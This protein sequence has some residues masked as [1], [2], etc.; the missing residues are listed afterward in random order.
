MMTTPASPANSQQQEPEKSLVWDL[1]T[2]LGHWTLVVCIAGAW[3]TSESERLAALH[4]AF[5]YTI[6]LIIGFRLVWGFIGTKYARWSN[7][8]P[9]IDRLSGYLRSVLQRRPQHFV[10]HNPLGAVGIYA[11]LGLTV[12]ISLTGLANQQNLGGH[13]MS[14]LHEASAEMLLVV[15][16]LHVFGVLMSSILHKENLIKSMVSGIKKEA[17]GSSI[18]RPFNWLGVSLVIAAGFTL[19][20]F[21]THPVA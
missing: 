19:I 20:Y 7:F 18:S 14:E 3:L 8:S 4:A 9:S 10:G 16:A 13:W 2:R 21:A 15:I 5:G 6:A 12:V 17:V 1:P 11:L